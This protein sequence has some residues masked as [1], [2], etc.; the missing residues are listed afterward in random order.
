MDDRKDRIPSDIEELLRPLRAPERPDPVVRAAHLQAMAATSPRRGGVLARVAAAGLV[1]KLVLAGTALAAT[2][3][4]LAAAGALPEPAQRALARVAEK[5]GI[6]LP[7]PPGRALPEERPDERPTPTPP[8][9]DV[10]DVV[11]DRDSYPDG[12]S[13]GDAVS[14]EASENSQGHRRDGDAGKPDDPG[15]QGKAPEDPG[16]PD[17]A[18]KPDDPGSQGKAPEDPGSQ[19]NKPEGAGKPDDVGTQGNRPEDPGSQGGKPTDPGDLSEM[20]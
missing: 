7:V 2:G 8:A 14:D 9:S 12:R 1:A 17:D 11:E 4:G 10:L 16:S 20:G 13:F 6:E 3:G 19:G 5:L 18:G 15:S